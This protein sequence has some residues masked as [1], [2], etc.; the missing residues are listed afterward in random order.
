M[1]S[2]SVLFVFIFGHSFIRVLQNRRL[3]RMASHT[4]GLTPTELLMQRLH[5][6]FPGAM[7]IAATCRFRGTLQPERLATSCRLLQGRHPALRS[8]IRH[9]NSSCE[10]LVNE[11]PACLPII[12]VQTDNEDA[13][14][15]AAIEACRVPFQEAE[16]PLLRLLVLEDVREQWTDVV[17][18]CHH[19]IADGKSLA[20]FF[21]ELA[22]LLAGSTLPPNSGAVRP[23]PMV[24]R[25]RGVWGPFFKEVAH[26]VS[27]R[28][29]IRR[30]PLARIPHRTIGQD[31]MRRKVWTE[32]GTIALVAATRREQT[33]I[34]GAIVA[35]FLRVLWM[36]Y[37]ITEKSIR[38]RT[39][40]DIRTRTTPPIPGDAI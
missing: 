35:S 8:S 30:E 22:Q 37:Q 29:R 3:G 12:R 18:V 14:S 24:P 5:Q 36:K 39:P 17:A 33:T 31:V 28:R 38:F 15:T 13:W 2:T 26:R 40:F 20:T 10:F 1:S 32:A 27:C 23:F 4:I 6:E 16:A 11:E 9:V 19:V 21:T 7:N 34:F 25:T